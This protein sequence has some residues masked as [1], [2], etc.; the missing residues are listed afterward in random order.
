MDTL[1]AYATVVGRTD[2][3]RD[4]T[5]SFGIIRNRPFKLPPASA[6]LTTL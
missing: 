6:N 4:S 1:R 5:Y 3:H 2:R